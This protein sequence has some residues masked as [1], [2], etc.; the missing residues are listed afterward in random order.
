[1][2]HAKMK[3]STAAYLSK[4]S[5]DADVAELAHC[6]EPKDTRFISGLHVLRTV[7][8][9]TMTTIK[10]REDKEGDEKQRRYSMIWAPAPS[11]C[12]SQRPNDIFETETQKQNCGPFQTRFK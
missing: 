8:D 10:F 6:N 11:T 9:R 4:K 1:M 5:N 12:S 2:V 3:E 7:S